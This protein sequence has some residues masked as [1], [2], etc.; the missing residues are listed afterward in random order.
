MACDVVFPQKSV[1]SP[2]KD[3]RP[4]AINTTCGRE[5][6]RFLNA[7][8]I[9]FCQ[10]APGKLILSPLNQWSWMLVCFHFLHPATTV[11]VHTIA[12]V[13]VCILISN[14]YGS[15]SCQ[16]LSF[17][18]SIFSKIQMRWVHFLVSWH[19]FGRR[20]GDWYPW[21]VMLQCVLF[22]TLILQSF[23]LLKVTFLISYAN[24][25]WWAL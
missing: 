11:N 9:F 20:A 18:S 1:Q 5:F 13:W 12:V 17:Q 6:I 19:R 10:H 16:Q 25:N 21:Y 14:L 4:D 3:S 22:K 23:P 8:C 7:R 15:F 24:M 2:L